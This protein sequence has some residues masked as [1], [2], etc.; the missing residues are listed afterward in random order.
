MENM[1]R[2]RKREKNNAEV[3]QGGERGRGKRTVLALEIYIF[4]ASACTKDGERKVAS[5]GI[6]MQTKYNTR[7]KI[8]NRA[9]GEKKESK[10]R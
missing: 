6:F 7:V 1:G 2:K 10:A 3:V 8:N 9:T 5:A 4:R